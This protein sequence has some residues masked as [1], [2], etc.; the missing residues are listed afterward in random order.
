MLEFETVSTDITVPRSPSM[1]VSERRLAANRNN[2]RKSTGPRTPEGKERSR[3]NALTHGL[4]ATKVFAEDPALVSRRSRD[5]SD[6][7]RPQ[8]DW[9]CWLVGQIGILS[10]MLDRAVQ[11]G[12]I[13]RDKI[14]IKAELSWDDDKRLEVVQLGEQLGNRPAVVVE[15]LRATP[16]G[17]EWLMGRWAMLAYAADNIQGGWSAEQKRL[18]FDLLATPVD[19]RVGIEPG[20]AID[21]RG[22]ALNKD[23]SQAEIARRQIDA[24]E[25]RLEEVEGLDEANRALAMADLH[26]DHDAELKRLHKQEG[27]LYSRI[28]WCLRELKSP[29]PEREC[30][31]WLKET[32]YGSDRLPPAAATLA[33]PTPLPEPTAVQDPPPEWAGKKA[34][35]DA[36]HA[37]FELEP[38][39]IPPIGVKPD[40]PRIL[41]DRRIDEL[42]K[43][44][45]RREARRQEVEKLRA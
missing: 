24:L 23:E 40:Y 2:A 21:L 41:S 13:A 18:A 11:M 31:R 3:G 30:P 9:Q 27:V 12:R 34:Y 32:W 1:E 37:P 28:R 16:Q 38:H 35:V 20:V 43:D 5:Y 4:C 8:N 33:P 22:K 19:F 25:D 6:A 45:S 39:E 7:L 42:E 15:K 44:E 14:A 36:I 10:L 26:D 17:C 29:R